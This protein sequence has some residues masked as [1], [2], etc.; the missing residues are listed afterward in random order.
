MR[1]FQ[2]ELKATAQ[3]KGAV[4]RNDAGGRRVGF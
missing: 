2:A 4:V 1:A 3:E